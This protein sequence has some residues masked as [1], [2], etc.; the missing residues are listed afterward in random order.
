MKYFETRFNMEHTYLTD[1]IIKQKRTDT[2]INNVGL[3]TAP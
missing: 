1:S 3:C 2:F